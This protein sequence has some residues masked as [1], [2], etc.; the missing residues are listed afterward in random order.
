V[1]IRRGNAHAIVAENANEIEIGGG[2]ELIH[3]HDQ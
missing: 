1:T 3:A 2:G